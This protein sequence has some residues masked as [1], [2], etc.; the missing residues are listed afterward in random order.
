M[1]RTDRF[2]IAGEIPVFVLLELLVQL[3]FVQL[4]CGSDVPTKSPNTKL[5]SIEPLLLERIQG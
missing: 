2:T 4:V 3:I 5:V 1:T